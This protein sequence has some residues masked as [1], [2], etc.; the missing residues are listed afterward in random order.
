[1]VVLRRV[2]AGTDGR[3][4]A[5]VPGHNV[6]P[7]RR[8]L[9]LE[10]V[11]SSYERRVPVDERWRERREGELQP[12]L[13]SDVYDRVRGRDQSKPDSQWKDGDLRRC[14]LQVARRSERQRHPG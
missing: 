10:Y 13:R 7:A 2:S 8:R 3:W 9:Q 4:W 11:R 6:S 5:V 14:D 12:L 1:M